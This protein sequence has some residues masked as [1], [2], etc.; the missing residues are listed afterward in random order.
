MSAPQTNVQSQKR[1][2]RGPLVGVAVAAAFG[3]GLILFWLF[4]ATATAPSSDSGNPAAP[5]AVPPSAAPAE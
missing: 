5:E 4:D 3:V 1:R 2:H